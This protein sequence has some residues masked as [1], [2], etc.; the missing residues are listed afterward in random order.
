MVLDHHKGFV[1]Y[2]LR[3]TGMYNEIQAKQGYIV[4]ALFKIER[5]HVFGT[6]NSFPKAY[7]L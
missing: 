2:R 1:T 7:L 4:R 6:N 3:T 5:F